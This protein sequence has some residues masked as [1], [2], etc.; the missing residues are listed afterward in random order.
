MPLIA[1]ASQPSAPRGTHPRQACLRGEAVRDV[2]PCDAED[3]ARIAADILP[4]SGALLDVVIGPW[5][6]GLDA[7]RPGDRRVG[8]IAM[9]WLALSR[10]DEEPR[11]TRRWANEGPN[12]PVAL[13]AA[14]HA[15]SAA[16]TGLWRVVGVDGQRLAL[17]DLLGLGAGH[18]PE[19]W[20]D[21]QPWGAVHGALAIGD[22]LAARLVR[23]P[24]GW[25][26]TVPLAVPGAPSPEVV[27]DWFAEGLGWLE[28]W[29]EVADPWALLRSHGAFLV[30]R[31][32]E[33][34]WARRARSTGGGGS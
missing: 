9:A 24:A 27:G 4:E 6:E 8:L 33:D 13:R 14:V 19:G 10:L 1:L 5:W 7:R 17:E 22:T 28:A 11:A 30:R 2:S 34:A 3:L 21:S 15:V 18:A 16:P 32:H 23:G 29:G 20:V 31:L 12:P 26:A 25:V